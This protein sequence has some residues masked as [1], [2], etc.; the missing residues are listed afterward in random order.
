MADFLTVMA[1]FLILWLFNPILGEKNI[2]ETANHKGF[3]VILSHK[4]IYLS[5]RSLFPQSMH[6]LTL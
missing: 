2:R 5:S 4:Y 3:A 1:D 6:R